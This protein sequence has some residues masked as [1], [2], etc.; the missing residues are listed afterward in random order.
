MPKD[1]DYSNLIKMY[2]TVRTTPQHLQCT[3]EFI[4]D[5]KTI[6]I[7]QDT[8]LASFDITNM[9]TNI[10]TTD[11]V[12]LLTQNFKNKTGK[13]E[14]NEACKRLLKLFYVKYIYRMKAWLWIPVWCLFHQ[15]TIP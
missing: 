11:L 13:Q 14:N 4:G 1:V 7:N 8:R 10:P 5:L 12:Q 9:C 15:H 2:H 3:V 6:P